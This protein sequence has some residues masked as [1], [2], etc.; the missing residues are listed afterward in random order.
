MG[1][2]G[3]ILLRSRFTT[4]AIFPAVSQLEKYFRACY[5]PRANFTADTNGYDP[6]MSDL[7]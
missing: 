6:P 1:F 4:I 5:W 3:L 2:D 7:L